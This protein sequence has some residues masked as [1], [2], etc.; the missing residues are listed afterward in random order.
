MQAI[1]VN[2]SPG[3]YLTVPSSSLWAEISR[4]FEVVTLLVG[5]CPGTR[6]W[7]GLSPASVKTVMDVVEVVRAVSGV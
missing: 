5:V 1:L 2:P 3:A 4:V 6:G 7:I